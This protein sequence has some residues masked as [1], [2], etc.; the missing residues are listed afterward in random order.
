MENSSLKILVMLSAICTAQTAW[1][2]VTTIATMDASW[3]VSGPEFA[4]LDSS[5]HPSHQWQLESYYDDADGVRH[6]VNDGA[7]GTYDISSVFGTPPSPAELDSDFANGAS[8]GTVGFSMNSSGGDSPTS[9]SALMEATAYAQK[10]PSHTTETF[11]SSANISNVLMWFPDTRTAGELVFDFEA[12]L[13]TDITQTGSLPWNGWGQYS[14]TGDV[15]WINDTGDL[16]HNSFFSILNTVHSES[17]S[18]T[19]DFS[20]SLNPYDPGS[21]FYDYAF[22]DGFIP[23]YGRVNL[24][25]MVGCLAYEYGP[26]DEPTN[27]IPTPGAVVLGSIGVGAIGWLRR[28][29]T[30]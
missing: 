16:G 2:N 9:A 27:P 12:T 17:A 8:N 15:R 19:I 24:Q 18:E 6:T 25:F 11:F 13:S 20:L 30:I 14:V 7:Y 3:S 10:D 29:R 4:A 28:R 21:D 22:P 5:Y 1:A 26:A 23:T